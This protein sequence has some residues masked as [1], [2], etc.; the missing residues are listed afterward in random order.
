MEH[1]TKNTNIQAAFDALFNEP[2][3]AYRTPWEKWNMSY[4][5][6]HKMYVK[7]CDDA[8]EHRRNPDPDRS[9]HIP[10]IAEQLVDTADRYDALWETEDGGTVLMDPEDESIEVEHHSWYYSQAM[11]RLDAIRIPT[12]E[13]WE[14][15]MNCKEFLEKKGYCREFRYPFDAGSFANIYE[16]DMYELVYDDELYALAWKTFEG[17]DV[18]SFDVDLDDLPF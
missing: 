6:W 13:D 16:R 1:Q 2:A 4:D 8:V 15:A 18:P 14:Y 12:V 9:F 11:N 17:N 10:S 5:E 3:P 7:A